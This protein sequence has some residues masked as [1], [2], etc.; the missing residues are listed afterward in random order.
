MIRKPP[1]GDVRGAFGNMDRFAPLL[2]W[3]RRYSDWPGTVFA[4]LGGLCI[5]WPFL[6]FLRVKTGVVPFSS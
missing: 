5:L 6:E 4:V 2:E 1:Y 3:P